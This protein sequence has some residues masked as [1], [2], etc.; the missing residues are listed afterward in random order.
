MWVTI[1]VPPESQMNLTL[2]KTFDQLGF[3]FDGARI[4]L[5]HED[6][7]FIEYAPG[8]PPAGVDAS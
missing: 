3:R 1:Y 8:P 6:G 7:T 2:P 5:V 4:G